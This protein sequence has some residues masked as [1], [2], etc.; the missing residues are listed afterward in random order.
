MT[1]QQLKTEKE[2]AL[3]VSRLAEGII[4]RHEGTLE[5]TVLVGVLTHGLPLAERIA[6]NIKN[7]GKGEVLVGKLDVSLYRDDIL[8]KGNF[9]TVKETHIP[10]DI[11][12][13]TIILVDDVLF[14]G[15]T[16]RAALDGLM[17]FGRPARIELAVLI[18][19]GHRELPI[20]PDFVGETISTNK[21][22]YVRVALIEVDA[23]E[24]I[25][26]EKSA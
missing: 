21:T 16:I 18:D 1:H 12:G 9:L 23:H 3:L 6:R 13:K 14:H 26:L 15:R 22:D 4:K 17:D 24:S 25:T 5:N 10:T 19:R 7:A 2:I 20:Q 11:T 8:D